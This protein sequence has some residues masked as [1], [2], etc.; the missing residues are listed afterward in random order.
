MRSLEKKGLST[1]AS[2]IDERRDCVLEMF[3]NGFS[4]DDM[5]EKL[6]ISSS[7]LRRDML[8]LGISFD[9]REIVVESESDGKSDVAETIEITNNSSISFFKGCT[10]YILGAMHRTE[11]SAPSRSNKSKCMQDDDKNIV[12]GVSS[13]EPP[14]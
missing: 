6:H 5:C 11:F 4:A 2:K 13:G 3:N 12:G 8:A 7:T 10:N 14:P 9:D 1:K